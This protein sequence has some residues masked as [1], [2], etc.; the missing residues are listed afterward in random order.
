[1]TKL[2]LVLVKEGRNTAL[3]KNKTH[4]LKCSRKRKAWLQIIK[5]IRGNHVVNFSEKHSILLNNLRD[6]DLIQSH[7]K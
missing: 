6:S 7:L 5:T 4:N 2:R 3:N 1:M